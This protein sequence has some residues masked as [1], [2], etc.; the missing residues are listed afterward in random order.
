M[1]VLGLARVDGLAFDPRLMRQR[2]SISTRKSNR[3]Q[4]DREMTRIERESVVQV[5]CVS[6]AISC[7]DKH[8]KPLEN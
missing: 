1:L 5:R 8:N 7:T 6:D 2:L 3:Y 4:G